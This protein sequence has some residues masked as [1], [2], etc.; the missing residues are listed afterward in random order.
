MA[1]ALQQAEIDQG[2]GEGVEIGNGIA[3][4]KMRAFNAESN[5]LAIDAFGGRTLAINLFVDWALSVDG[6][7]Q[8]GAN[9]GRHRNRATAF[10]SA[11]MMNGTRLFDEFVL[12]LL[13]KE[14]ADILA[15]FMF[16]DGDSSVK[17]SSS[18]IKHAALKAA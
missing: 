2:V 7:T 6:V 17:F 10:A 3:I 9:A 14:R 8:A 12:D 16:D 1:E 13:G 15:A 18:L 4:A 5:C 11:F